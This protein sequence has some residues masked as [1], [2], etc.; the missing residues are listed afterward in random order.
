MTL[1]TKTCR[2]CQTQ[3]TVAPEDFEFYT[4]MEVPAPLDCPDCRMQKRMAWRNER[5]LYRRKC[6]L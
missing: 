1:E 4:K 5:V 2:S 6:D 3:F